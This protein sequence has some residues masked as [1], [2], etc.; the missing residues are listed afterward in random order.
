MEQVAYPRESSD[1]F[2][3]NS[4]QTSISYDCK[5]LQT[6]TDNHSK[7]EPGDLADRVG[8]WD[9]LGSVSL[10]QLLYVVMDLNEPAK[11]CNT[12]FQSLHLSHAI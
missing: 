11:A 12:A 1:L 8:N 2:Q 3:L 7:C 6:F 9:R 10:Q 5:R 4:D